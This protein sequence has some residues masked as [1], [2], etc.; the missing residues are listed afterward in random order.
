MYIE[1]DP[2]LPPAASKPY[3]LP[4]KHQEW[5]RKELENLEKAEIIQRSLSPYASPIIVVRRKYPP[6]CPVQETKNIFVDYRKL[7]T[8]LPTVCGGKSS[9]EIS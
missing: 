5:V 1:T 2:N 9:G 3:A 6:S 4:L 8:K 7:D